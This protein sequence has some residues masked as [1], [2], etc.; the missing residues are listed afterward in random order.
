MVIREVKAKNII[1]KSNLP[2]ADYVINPYVGCSHACIYCY[3]CF[4]KRFTNHQEDWGKF[5]DVKINAPD[6][7]PRKSE[8]YHN[9]YIFI[10][11]VTDPYLPHENRYRL[12]RRILEK[13]IP[14]RPNIGIQSKSALISRDIDLFKQFPVCET[15]LSITTLNDSYRKEIEPYTSSVQKRIE[16][17]KELKK[18]GLDTYVFIGPI[19]PYITDW[20]SIILETKSFANSY[21]FENLNMYWAVA[22]NIYQWIRK[23]HLDLFHE[24]QSIFSKNSMYWYHVEQEIRDFCKQNGINGRIFFHHSSMKKNR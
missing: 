5:L 2:A 18:A 17:L 24:Y 20:K 9:K 12:T 21:M 23:L 7:V 22:K 6:L 13:L 14:L 8:K 10:S 3:A 15:G 4:M 1:T 11:S 19:L 16:A